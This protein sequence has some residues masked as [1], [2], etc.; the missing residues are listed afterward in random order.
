MTTLATPTSPSSAF[1]NFVLGRLRLAYARA[2][3]ATNEIA[4]IGTAL[5]GGH[6]G[7]EAA[8]LHLHEA[9]LS[10]LIEVSS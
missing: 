3:V 10:H 2:R 7:P 8:L 5:R 9:G 4:T 1:A 6:I